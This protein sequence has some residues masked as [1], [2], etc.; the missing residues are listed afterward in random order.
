MPIYHGFHSTLPNTFTLKLSAIEW[1]LYPPIVQIFASI[2]PSETDADWDGYS[3]PQP[4]MQ[5]YPG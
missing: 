5:I 2:T 4:I 3:N 1:Q